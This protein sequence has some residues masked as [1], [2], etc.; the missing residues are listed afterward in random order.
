MNNKSTKTKEIFNKI[1]DGV[2]IIVESGE[3]TNFLK[4]SKYFH[5][6]SFNNIVLIYSQM[7]DATQVAGFKTWEKM[8][9]K[10]KKGAKGIQIIYPV[11]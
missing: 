3:Y 7:E 5:N 9:R 2:S 1:I 10:L 4:F 8:G 6:Y 11:K